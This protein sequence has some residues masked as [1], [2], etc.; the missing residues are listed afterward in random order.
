VPA[1]GGGAPILFGG[2]PAI[3]LLVKCTVRVA[4][5]R[6][7]VLRVSIHTLADRLVEQGEIV[8]QVGVVSE[9][10]TKVLKVI[11]FG[12]LIVKQGGR[13]QRRIV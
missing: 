1:R 3:A 8:L 10:L 9:V 13:A 4:T 5:T 2:G 12:P 6:V 7:L 11:H